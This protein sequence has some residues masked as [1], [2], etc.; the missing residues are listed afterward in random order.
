MTVVGGE[1]V[2]KVGSSPLVETL[3]DFLEEVALENRIFILKYFFIWFHRTAK[4]TAQVSSLTR[5]Q[6]C[7]CPPALE[8]RSF[9]HWT[10]KEV[11][12]EFF[13]LK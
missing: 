8:V 7:P 11:P 4:I 13:F 6:T 10:S 12:T 3:G 5:D 1:Q 9:N 2:S